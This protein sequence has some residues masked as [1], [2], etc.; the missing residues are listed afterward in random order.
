MQTEGQPKEYQPRTLQQ[1]RALHLLFDMLADELNSA[2]LDMRKVL[3]PGIAIPWTKTSVKE[4]LWRPVQRSMFGKVSTIQIT[5]KELQDTFDVLNRHLG[6]Q[7]GLHVPFPS[8]EE[9]I[10]RQITPEP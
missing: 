5:T 2:G 9:I 8:I 10:M 3:K 4:F 7:F 6:E 1:N